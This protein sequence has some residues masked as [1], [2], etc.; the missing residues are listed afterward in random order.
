MSVCHVWLR[1]CF[2]ARA[3]LPYSNKF[4]MIWLLLSYRVRR[5]QDTDCWELVFQRRRCSPS[6]GLPRSECTPR[7]SFRR[8]SERPSAL[9]DP[10]VP[11]GR[12]PPH[13]RRQRLPH[14]ITHIY[15]HLHTHTQLAVRFWLFIIPLFRCIPYVNN[16]TSSAVAGQRWPRSSVVRTSVR[17]ADFF[18]PAR[19]LWLKGDFF[20]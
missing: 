5:Q 1:M 7:T 8:P 4:D 20:G 2:C 12:P 3:S 18:C 11:S 13:R 15:T 9:S 14:L 10:C 17:T 6:E 19:D 16:D